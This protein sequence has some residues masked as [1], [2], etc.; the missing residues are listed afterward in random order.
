MANVGP[1]LTIPFTVGTG[2]IVGQGN[3]PELWA[4]YTTDD[5]SITS[6]IWIDAT[7]K[8]RSF[9]LSRGRE[10]ELQQMDA[11]TMTITLD[12]RDRSFDPNSNALI[13]PLNRWWLRVQFSSETH[14][15]FK[16]YAESYENQWPGAGGW[17]DAIA[18][19]N[20]S[21]EFKILTLDALP[22]TSPARG[23]YAE[24]VAYDNPAG[25]W[26]LNTDPAVQLQAPVT[27]ETEAIPVNPV[28][29]VL[30]QL[31]RLEGGRR[32]YPAPNK[33]WR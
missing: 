27:I 26:R 20:C 32:A 1:K 7:A 25:Y 13:K 6:P 30:I 16:G 23:S 9:S 19:V 2:K 12:N 29:S 24:L 28:N 4:L 31:H 14:D 22:T 21:D 3:L 17:S 18:V 8:V 15:L 5:V 33:G 11:G 10:T